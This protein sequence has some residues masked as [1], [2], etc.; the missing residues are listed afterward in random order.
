MLIRSSRIYENIG[1]MY[2][3]KD[4]KRLIILYANESEDFNI[5]IMNFSTQ[6]DS[7]GGHLKHGNTLHSVNMYYGIID[8]PFLNEYVKGQNVIINPN[9]VI[10]FDENMY[11][12]NL[13]GYVKDSNLSVSVFDNIY[14]SEYLKYDKKNDVL[15]SDPRYYNIDHQIVEI[16]I[17]AP[18]K[19]DIMWSDGKNGDDGFIKRLF[20]SEIN[21]TNFY[22]LKEL[23]D[24]HTYIKII[25]RRFLDLYNMYSGNNN[26]FPLT[27]ER[28]LQV[29]LAGS[30]ARIEL[31]ALKAFCE[32]YSIII[33]TKEGVGI[34]W[35][36]LYLKMNN[37]EDKMM[38]A[39]VIQQEYER[40]I[41][42][43]YELRLSIIHKDECTNVEI[44]PNCNDYRFELNSV[45][46]TS[47]GEKVIIDAEHQ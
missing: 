40:F 34:P 24:N 39:N 7:I 8:K 3:F 25:K 17:D 20:L 27:K 30:I 47:H 22:T 41:D 19:T 31:F 32:E 1:D 44:R 13:D 14:R 9:A 26:P 6:I 28:N 18:F 42:M 21:H 38:F 4:I 29:D 37:R 33:D 16:N 5:A 2:E 12:H 46:Y 45:A 23:I 10:D 36:K 15:P 43:G 35:A 11:V